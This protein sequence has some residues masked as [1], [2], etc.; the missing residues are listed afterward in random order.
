MISRAERS[1]LFEVVLFD[2][3]ADLARGDAE[4]TAAFAWFHP[5][6]V[7]ASMSFAFSM[8]SIVEAGR[9]SAARRTLP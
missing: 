4:D 8:S 7:S 6:R 5:V 3:V 9:P 2:L 1:G